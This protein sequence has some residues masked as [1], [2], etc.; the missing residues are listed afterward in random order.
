MA[1]ISGSTGRWKMTLPALFTTKDGREVIIRQATAADEP[2][3]VEMYHRLSDE[4]KK[5]RFHTLPRNLTD[6]KICKEALSL[7]FDPGRQAAVIAA[8]IS[9]AREQIVAMAQLNRATTLD[10]EAETAVVVRDDYQ[11]IGVGKRILFELA[12]CGQEMNITRFH[13]WI[14][15]ENQRILNIISGLG[16]P[17]ELHTSR[18]ETHLIVPV[19]KNIPL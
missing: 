3:L 6:D 2:L 9:D 10:T 16:F 14:M 12:R 7:L 8:V 13:A 5:L 18:G 17:I 1:T 4:T 19:P 15:A 11:G